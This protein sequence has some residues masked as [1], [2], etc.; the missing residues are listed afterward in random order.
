MGQAYSFIYNLVEEY[1]SSKGLYTEVGSG[2]SGESQDVKLAF[3]AMIE[4]WENRHAPELLDLPGSVKEILLNMVR[5]S[6]LDTLTE[7]RDKYRQPERD[8]SRH[9]AGHAECLR[10]GCHDFEKLIHM[11]GDVEQSGDQIPHAS[12]LRRISP[13]HPTHF[14]PGVSGESKGWQIGQERMGDGKVSIEAECRNP[15]FCIPLRDIGHQERL[16]WEEGPHGHMPQEVGEK[17]EPALS[18]GSREE[19][20]LQLNFF[21]AMGYSEDVVRRI[22]ARTGPKEVSQILD[23]VQ[24]EQDKVAEERMEENPQIATANAP[25]NVQWD[26]S[27]RLSGEDFVLGVLKEAAAKC[28]FSEEKVMEVYSNLPGLSTGELLEELHKDA[29][30]A[31]GGEKGSRAGDE[32]ERG[33]TDLQ[34]NLDFARIPEVDGKVVVFKDR[35]QYQGRNEMK[36]DQEMGEYFPELHTMSGEPVAAHEAASCFPNSCSHIQGPPESTYPLKIIPSFKKH[37]HDRARS[38]EQNRPHGTGAET[39]VTGEQRFHDGLQKPFELKLTDDPGDP[40]L[41]HVIIDGSNLAMT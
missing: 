32:K 25:R 17:E 30:R 12:S 16:T 41:R 7:D 14:G 4:R 3:K 11:E 40:S 28:G 20:G 39:M 5:E 31:K 29:Q 21:T 2:S 35:R 27:S 24:Q 26:E 36:P 8:I 1:K 34:R 10:K 13:F 23:L 6:R 9:A 19:I 15:F 38:R 33:C 18:V 37:P 22:L